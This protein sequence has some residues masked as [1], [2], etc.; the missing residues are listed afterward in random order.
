MT[1]M[2]CFGLVKAL[3]LNGYI[4]IANSDIFFDN[5]LLNL[6]KTSLSKTKSV[7][8]LLRFE[9]KNEKNLNDL[10]VDPAIIKKII[11]NVVKRKNVKYNS[12]LISEEKIRI[13]QFILVNKILFYMNLI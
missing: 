2:H 11:E 10:N 12:L 8:A 5:T 6:E 7:Y 1:Y 3:K 9:F 13:N 4:I